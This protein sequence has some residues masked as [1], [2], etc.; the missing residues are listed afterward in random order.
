MRK[1]KLAGNG[2]FG[3]IYGFLGKPLTPPADDAAPAEEPA[4][5]AAPAAE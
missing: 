1:L 3:A 4:A 2:G 5:D